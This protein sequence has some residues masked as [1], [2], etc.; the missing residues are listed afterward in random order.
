MVKIKCKVDD[1]P[2]TKTRK[3]FLRQFFTLRPAT[4]Y[5]E[6]GRKQCNERTHRSFSDL[7]AL[8]QDRFKVTSIN[9]IIRIVA[10]LNI[11]GKCDIVWCTQV[12]KFV[13]R[14]GMNNPGLPF[15][16]RYSVDY[17]KK[18]V[19]TDGIH[20]QQLIDI[21]AKEKVK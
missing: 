10:Q 18:E 12:K 13:V 9:A 17:F 11:E 15:V 16:T 3:E 7:L 14:G 21:R 20:L 4:Y 5:V 1:I 19:G 6:N 8:T 2:K